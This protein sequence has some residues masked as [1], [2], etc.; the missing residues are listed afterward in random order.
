MGIQTFVHT[1]DMQILCKLKLN[2]NTENMQKTHTQTR[3]NTF[4]KVKSEAHTTCPAQ[5]RKSAKKLDANSQFEF[6]KRTHHTGNA[7]HDQNT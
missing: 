5:S 7:K 4:R 3:R 2:Q 1:N 6:V